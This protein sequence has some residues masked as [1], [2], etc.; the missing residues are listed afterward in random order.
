[1]LFANGCFNPIAL[2]AVSGKFRK[3]LL[4]GPCCEVQHKKYVSRQKRASVYN[5]SME[6]ELK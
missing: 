4:S 1:L 3:L 2:F 5:I 6:I